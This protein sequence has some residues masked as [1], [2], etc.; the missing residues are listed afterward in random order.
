MKTFDEQY[1]ELVRDIIDN[2]YSSVDRTGVGTRKIFGAS[3]RFRDTVS[4]F[5]ILECKKTNFESLKKE[6]LWIYQDQSN[7]VRLLREKYG[8]NIWNEW[9]RAD[10]TIGDAYGEQVRKHGQLDKLI[11]GLRELPQG[12]RHMINLWSWEDLGNMA[13]PPCCFQTIWDVNDG[14][15]NVH[16]TQRSGDVGLGVPFNVSQYCLLQ[17]MIA[18]ISELEVGEYFHVITNAHLYTDHI[19]PIQQI[20][21]RP[22]LNSKPQLVL[23]KTVSDFYEFQPHSI[24]LKDYQHHPH[25]KMNVAV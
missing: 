21:E 6:L 19:E 7:D 20:F 23:D 2:G 8:V 16:V 10:G 14:R 24:E 9:E 17:H 4:Q 15:L 5:P 22:S 25:I 12:R 11:R 1:K 3:F 13:L 18:Q